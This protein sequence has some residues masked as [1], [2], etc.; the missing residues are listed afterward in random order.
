[1]T[2]NLKEE[3]M[4]EDNES[5]SWSNVAMIIAFFLIL[6]GIIFAAIFV[7]KGKIIEGIEVTFGFGFFSLGF[8][9][10]AYAFS[11]KS[12]EKMKSIVNVEF[13]KVINMLEDARIEFIKTW[14]GFPG[15]SPELFTWKTKSC[16][17][18]AVELLKKDEIKKYI[19]PE[20]QDK[21]FHYFNISFKHFFK[22]PNWKKETNSQTHLIESYA[23]LDDYYNPQR[24]Q[25]LEEYINP[26]KEKYFANFYE[27]V[28]KKKSR[29]E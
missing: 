26:R 29:E 28:I 17:E 6:L 4:A 3:K 16:V 20:Y 1:M 2:T 9:L 27:E 13:L 23:L 24:R 22:I 8:A 10:Y 14:K 5:M 18:I 15:Y 12:D 21:L 19:D 25:E 7:F 11:M